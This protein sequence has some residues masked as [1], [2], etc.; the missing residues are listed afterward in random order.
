M[1]Y[2]GID[3]ACDKHNC[4]IIDERKNILSEFAIANSRDGFD[5]LL[6]EISRFDDE[7]SIGL[8]AT[9]IYGGN[10]VHYLHQHNLSTVTINPLSAKRLLNAKSLRKT[11]TDKTDAFGIAKLLIQ[12][13]QNPD[14]PISY[15]TSELKSLTRLRFNMVNDRSRQ[16]IR[17]KR[18]ITMLFPEFKTLFHDTFCSTAIA[19]LKHYPSAKDLSRCRINTLTN[20]LYSASRGRYDSSKALQI[21]ELAGHSIGTYSHANVMALLCCLDLIA[22][23]DNQIKAIEKEIADIMKNINSTITTVPGIGTVLGAVILSEIGNIER[24]SNANKLLAFAGLDPSI[25]Q[26]GK[27][28][29]SA[30]TMVKHGSPYLRNAVIQAARQIARYNDTFSVFLSKKLSEGKHYNV[31]VSHVA[32]KLVRVIFHLLSFNQS[33]S[34]LLLT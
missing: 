23:Y 13:F 11:K 26:S 19:V 16:K 17:A 27:F 7:K 22:F 10:L 21:K 15:H 32:K 6:S 25:Y 33:F 2:V 18:L 24:F 1:I 28:K 30:G 4:C 34:D 12:E 9:G 3:I 20:I 8:E 29:A 14:T 31:A 5:L